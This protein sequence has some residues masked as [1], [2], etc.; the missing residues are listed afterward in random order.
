MNKSF[1]KRN[2]NV[3]PNI[4]DLMISYDQNDTDIIIEQLNEELVEQ[5]NL[6]KVLNEKNFEENKKE[7]EDFISDN[8]NNINTQVSNLQNLFERYKGIFNANIELKKEHEEY[9]ECISSPDALE[10]A[11]DLKKLKTLKKDILLFLG[12]NGVHDIL[13]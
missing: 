7:I 11:N 4:M 3:T 5:E 6:N 13:N 1:N 2:I 9:N 12:K 10:V 8:K